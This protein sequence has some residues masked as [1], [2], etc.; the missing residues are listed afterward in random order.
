LD[1]LAARFSFNDLPAAFLFFAPPL[2][3]FA[4]VTSRPVAIRVRALGPRRGSLAR[5]AATW[6]T[7]VTRAL[8]DIGATVEHV[9][10]ARV[11]ASAKM[12]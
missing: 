7:H 6:S 9:V 2:S 11:M 12:A 1:F 4:M 10:A 3:L 8:R 5:I